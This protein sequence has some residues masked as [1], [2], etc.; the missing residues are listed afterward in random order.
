M[1]KAPVFYGQN[2]WPLAVKMFTQSTDHNPLL[3]KPSHTSEKR[4]KID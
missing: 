3:Q 2:S 1:H 4:N